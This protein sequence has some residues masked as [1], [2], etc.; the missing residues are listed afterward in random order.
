LKKGAKE[1]GPLPPPPKIYY[2][3][4]VVYSL[5]PKASKKNGIFLGPK[6]GPVLQAACFVVVLQKKI[7]RYANDVL[8]RLEKEGEAASD[9]KGPVVLQLTIESPIPSLEILA[10]TFLLPF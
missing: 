1:N 10:P 9:I 6:N 3:F 2:I 8:A 7:L 4:H 5:S